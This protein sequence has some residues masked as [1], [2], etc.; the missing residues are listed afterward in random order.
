MTKK[1]KT[2]KSERYISS[3]DTGTLLARLC[4][5]DT[6]VSLQRL[7]QLRK[8]GKLKSKTQTLGNVIRQ[9][10][11]EESIY[12]LA[13]S[14]LNKKL[15]TQF[16]RKIADDSRLLTRTELKI[17]LGEKYIPKLL[18]QITSV[19]GE[20]RESMYAYNDIVALLRVI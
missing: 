16:R 18:K 1:I 10:Y 3:A 14:R 19:S 12:K 6:P 8:E 13:Q 17:L 5:L 20:G 15:N 7:N 2:K 4:G 11:S 9:T